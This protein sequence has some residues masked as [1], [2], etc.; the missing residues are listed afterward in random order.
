MLLEK[1]RLVASVRPVL[2]LVASPAST[3][4]MIC[5]R[6][7]FGAR[8]KR[9]LDDQGGPSGRRFADAM[10]QGCRYNALLRRWR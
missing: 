5:H 1:K 9:Q 7:T 4:W 8:G 3:Y 10:I 6:S 2:I